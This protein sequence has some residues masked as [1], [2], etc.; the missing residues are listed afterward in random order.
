MLEDLLPAEV[1]S[2]A[3]RRDE[4]LACLLPEEATQL[5]QAV[6]SRIR[7]F[8]SARTCARQ[9]LRNLGY[10]STPI[11]RGV[12]G[13][14]IWPAGVVGSITHCDGYRAAAVAMQRDV[15]TV[16]IDAEIHEELPAG[17]LEHVSNE[18]ERAWLPEAPAGIHWDRL[19]FCA[20]ESVYKAWFP[21]TGRWLDFE[22]AMVTF[23][24]V[25]GTFHARL[26]VPTLPVDGCKLTG[27]T[28]RFSVQDGLVLTAIALIR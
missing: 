11:L 26:L 20:K 16:G 3:V 14:P 9:A 6:E 4:P 22:D 13:E 27:F 8:T 24:L 28:G 2:V 1:V 19:L 18:E 17:V 10:P 5:G 23:N 7:E 21:L 12:N 25:E 15:L